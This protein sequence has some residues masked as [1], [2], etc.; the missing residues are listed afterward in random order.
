MTT[1]L[2]Y[3]I[4]SAFVLSILY[5]PYMLM[6]KN[7][8]FFR[9]NRLTLLAILLMS[10]LL[11][12]CNCP[13]MSL[14]NQPVVQVAQQQMIDIGIPIQQSYYLQSVQDT[15]NTTSVSWFQVVSMLYIIGMSVVLA[16]RTVQFCRMGWVIRG[17]SLWRELRDGISI[18]CHADD[19]VP[20]SWLNNIVISKSDYDSDGREIILHEM[21]HIHCRHSIDI[22]FLTLVQML[23]WWNPLVYV[24]GASLRDV[25]EYEADDY[26]LRQGITLGGYQKILIKKAVGASSY[27]FANNFNHSLTKKRITMM[28]KKESNPW[29]RSKV[30]Y[31]IPMAAIALSAF[32]TPEFIQPIEETVRNLNDEFVKPEPVDTCNADIN[33]E[34]YTIFIDG[35][36]STP[37]ELKSLDK[38]TIDNANIYNDIDEVRTVFGKQMK[39]PV[40]DIHTKTIIGTGKMDDDGIGL[41][42][43]YTSNNANDSVVYI[44]DG[45]VVESIDGIDPSTVDNISVLKEKSA[46]EMYLERQKSNPSDFKKNVSEIKGIIVIN[47]KQ[48]QKELDGGNVAAERAK[49][50]MAEKARRESDAKQKTTNNSAT[51]DN[52]DSTLSV[53]IIK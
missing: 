31:F 19:V 10:L 49:A 16:I 41:R 13:F 53:T 7:E 21:G 30:F 32:A 45:N 35:K 20:F 25:H 12:L 17:G 15:R 40:I 37:E 2:L 29:R 36:V 22:I 3:A 11:P 51:T 43:V 5:V 24:L 9:F 8:K 52:P 6:L 44:L 50:E 34:D 27:A 18:Y 42:V 14:D 33:P 46:K 38:S 26:V 39:K 48:Y 28:C 47:T 4:K 1:F 23:Q